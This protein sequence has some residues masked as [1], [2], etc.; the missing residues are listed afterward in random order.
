MI[1]IKLSALLI[2]KLR[3]IRFLA[4]KSLQKTNLLKQEGEKIVR[5]NALRDLLQPNALEAAKHE[6]N[7]LNVAEL[8][9][10]LMD[11]EPRKRVLAF[12]L[13]EKNKA[14]AVFEYLRPEE[15]ADLI[16]AMENPE[17]M[18]LLEALDPDDRV[19]LFE[20][21]PAKVTKRLIANFCSLD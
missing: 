17:V 16:Q 20:E 5:Q 12:R 14:I 9:R 19:R 6:A 15:Q 1:L 3:V 2:L 11:I 10:L 8:V 7:R 4:F 18:S 13:L 21:L